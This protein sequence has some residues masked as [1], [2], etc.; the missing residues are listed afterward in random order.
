MGETTTRFLSSTLLTFK[1]KS[2]GAGVEASVDL[3]ELD[4]ASHCS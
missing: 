3:A 4:L 1:G 2:M